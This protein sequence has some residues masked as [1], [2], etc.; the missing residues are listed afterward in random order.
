MNC[1]RLVLMAMLGVVLS[2]CDNSKAVDPPAELVDIE[3]V[4]QVKRLWSD[5]LS[6]KSDHLRLGAATQYRQQ[7]GVCRGHKGEVIA[8]TADK[9]KQLWRIKTKLE[10]SAGPAAADGLVVVG[11]ANGELVALEAESGK[12]RWRHQLSGEMLS[13]ALVGNGAGNCAYCGWPI[14]GAECR[15]WQRALDG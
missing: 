7:C 13:K 3:P 2:A 15:R 11:S 8:L 12:Q 14:A 5:S 6:G 4:L 9:G 1:S 10:L